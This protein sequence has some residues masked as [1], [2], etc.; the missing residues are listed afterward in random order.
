MCGEQHKERKR[1]PRRKDAEIACDD[2]MFAE[3]TTSLGKGEWEKAVAQYALAI[4]AKIQQNPEGYSPRWLKRMWKMRKSLEK[5]ASARLGRGDARVQVLDALR[6]AFRHVSFCLAD[7]GQ[8]RHAFGAA[9]NNNKAITRKRW[10]LGGMARAWA[11]I[12]G[13]HWWTSN[14]STSWFAFTYR[15]ILPVWTLFAVTDSLLLR[16][17]QVLGQ[18]G[19][20]VA[21]TW[22]TAFY[23]G[24]VTMTTLGY[25]DLHPRTDCPAALLACVIQA[26]G[27]YVLLAVFVSLLIQYAGAH[28]FT[29]PKWDY[30]Y[31]TTD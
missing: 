9:Y 24:A 5:A 31:E 23:F 6:R 19:H 28:P 11:V 14:F 16:A 20:P 8:H 13:L 27:G 7:H 17:G 21:A 15:T 4:C 29:P 2:K 30:Q 3:A 18:G 22:P 26:F 1:P 10:H 12:G 25:G